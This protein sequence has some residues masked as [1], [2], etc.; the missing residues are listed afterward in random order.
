M[1]T[2]AAEG[3]ETQQRSIESVDD[4]ART[5]PRLQTKHWVTAAVLVDGLVVVA[6]CAALAAHRWLKLE[7]LLSGD[8]VRWLLEA[9]RGASGEAPYKDF[10]WLY[11][12]MG[13]WAIAAPF[14]LFG[15]TFLVAQTVVDL[16]SF[17][18][19]GLVWLVARN[20][21]PR[22]PALLAAVVTAVSG[23]SNTG[24]FAL[25][26]LQI[27]MPAQLTG[28]IGL[29]MFILPLV[30]KL[31]S[32]SED[33]PFTQREIAFLLVGG[34]TACLSKVEFMVG[35]IGACGYFALLHRRGA[36]GPSTV[37]WLNPRLVVAFAGLVPSVLIYLV[38]VASVGLQPLVEGLGCYGVATQTCPWWPTWLGMFSAAAGAAKAIVFAAAV[39]LLRFPSFIRR[40]GQRYLAFL[41]VA[42]LA[43]FCI[44]AQLPYA[45]EGFSGSQSVGT[46]ATVLAL[47]QLLSVNGILLP[48]MWAGIAYV[49]RDLYRR[50]RG[51]SDLPR[52]Q[53]H[54]VWLLIAGTAALI[55]SRGLFGSLFGANSVVTSSAY[56]LLF[57]LAPWLALELITWTTER[58]KR[59]A[60]VLVT[61]SFLGYG[62]TRLMYLAKT[63]RSSSYETLQTE[64]GPVKLHAYETSAE[65]YQQIVHR[66]GDGA[67]LLEVPFGG[68]LTFAA[69][70]RS[71]LFSN[72]FLG[73]APSERVQQM[74]LVRIRSSPPDVVI[75]TDEPRFGSGFGL[76]IGCSFPRITVAPP[77]RY[78]TA[79][80]LIPALA[81]IKEEYRPV[82]HIADRMLLVRR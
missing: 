60:V 23:A 63:A 30:D 68:G 28:S 3:S 62:A 52:L 47:S 48:V 41:C 76:A 38:I 79:G 24:N 35:M 19:C 13:L 44:W 55:N 65:L 1:T 74:D 78:P 5:P 37:P 67:R 7:N 58:P 70:R 53:T 64:A 75:V 17:S 69:H 9:Y 81:V 36:R 27:Y 72:Q 20:V 73:L 42:V 39:S 10:A 18:L 16:L 12:P 15:S 61:V 26:S 33:R 56:P 31:Q 59:W 49:S 66:T 2:G 77:R 57:I 71:S 40:Y 54:S 82:F 29:L 8:N 51:E 6:T 43:V 14:R 11:P 45:V 80:P 50:V 25:F 22:G 4:A 34:M 46:S 21:L 32:D